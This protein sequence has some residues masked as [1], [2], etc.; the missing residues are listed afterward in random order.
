MEA[1]HEKQTSTPFMDLT[2][3]RDCGLLQEINR[4]LLHPMGLALAVEADASNA[5]TRIVGV[6][7]MRSDPEGYVFGDGDEDVRARKAACVGAMFEAKRAARERAFGWH[8]EPPP[9]SQAPSP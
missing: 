8:V 6:L 4:L 9:P 5:V 2:E 7:D 1:P 3:F